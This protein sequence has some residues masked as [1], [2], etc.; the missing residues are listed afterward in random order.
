[1]HEQ[2]ALFQNCSFCTDP[3]NIIWFFNLSFSLSALL[4][5]EPT[6]PSVQIVSGV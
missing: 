1:M 5:S 3:Q 6:V 4:S 2:N